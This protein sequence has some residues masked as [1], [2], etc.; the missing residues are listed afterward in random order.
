MNMQAVYRR[1][2]RSR[3]KNGGVTLSDIAKLAGVSA[4]TASRAL[5][6][7]EQVS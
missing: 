2:R 6:T 5:N 3:K 7:P 1:P 4:I